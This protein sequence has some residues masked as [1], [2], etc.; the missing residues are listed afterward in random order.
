MTVHQTLG[1]L[2]PSQP[3]RTGGEVA[4]CWC[5]TCRPITLADMRMVLC[6]D[7]GNKRCPKANFHGNPCTNSNE[8][9]QPGSA[10]PAPSVLLEGVSVPPETVAGA[11]GSDQPETRDPIVEQVRAKFH[12]RSQF[13]IAKYGTTL[14]RT[15]LLLIDWLRHALEEHMDSVLYLQRAINELERGR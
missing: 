5:H 1:D 11:Q 3:V 12:E 9:G 4:K 8:P 7:C 10:Y 6:P 14:A 15:D 2:H 13:G